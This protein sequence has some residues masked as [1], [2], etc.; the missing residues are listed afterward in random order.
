MQPKSYSGGYTQA[1]TMLRYRTKQA[2]RLVEAIAA[3]HKL[4]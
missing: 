4:D 2:R 1:A 3:L